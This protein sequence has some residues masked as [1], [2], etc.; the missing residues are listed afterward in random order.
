[1]TRRPA[2]GR[3]LEAFEFKS[4]RGR[5]ADK[6]PFAACGRRLPGARWYHCLWAL[7]RRKVR[8]E[9]DALD[10]SLV[11]CGDLERERR[12]GMIM[13]DLHRID[14]MPTRMLPERKQEID[15]GRGRSAAIDR[16]GIAEGLAEMPAFGVRLEIKETDDVGGCGHRHHASSGPALGAL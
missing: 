14:A 13:P 6:R 2:L 5:A 10:R 9:D 4:R 7:A 1:S 8:S 12:T 16:A 15:R 11:C 3:G